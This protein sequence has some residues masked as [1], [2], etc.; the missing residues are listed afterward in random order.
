LLASVE[1]GVESGGFN[2][3]VLYVMLNGLKLFAVVS[4][5]EL[6]GVPPELELWMATLR[7][8]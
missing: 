1:R 7:A 5:S 2:S 4:E 6:L 3:P 8:R